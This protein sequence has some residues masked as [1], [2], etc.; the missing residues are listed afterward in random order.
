[1]SSNADALWTKAIADGLS[2]SIRGIV[3]PQTCLA[4]FARPAE[5]LAS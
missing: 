2:N 4:F 1:M 3:Y 5:G